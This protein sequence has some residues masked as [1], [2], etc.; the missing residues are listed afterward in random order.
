MTYI[1]S[2]FQYLLKNIV[3]NAHKL[4]NIAQ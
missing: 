1:V 2:V 4:E 3:T